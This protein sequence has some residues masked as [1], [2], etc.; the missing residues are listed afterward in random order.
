M[1]PCN[2]RSKADICDRGLNLGGAIFPPEKSYPA[3]CEI[4]LVQQQQELQRQHEEEEKRLRQRQLDRLNQRLYQQVSRQI[5]EQERRN[6]NTT[7]QFATWEDHSSKFGSRVLSKWGY[8]GGGLGKDGNGIT[9]P[10]KVKPLVQVLQDD[11]RWPDKTTLIIGDSMINNIEEERLRRYRVKVVP[12]P[13]ATIKEMYRHITPLLKKKPTQVI[14]HVGTNDAPYKTSEVIVRDLQWLQAYICSNLPSR[15]KVVIS[16]PIMRTDNKLAN[17]RIREVNNAFRN[18]PNT[19][20]N[21]KFDGQCLGKKGLHLN[22]RGSGK[23]AVNFIA[24]MQC[25]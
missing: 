22:Q 23:L 19:I 6:D 2:S 9:S 5:Q 12:C 17:S 16:T 3:S 8:T 13:G 14:V 18:V 1:Y 15:S 25:V 21:D 20:L 11:D 7:D 10:I 4:E 24:Q